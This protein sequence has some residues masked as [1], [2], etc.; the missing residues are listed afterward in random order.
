MSTC[1][2]LKQLHMY[3]CM[4]V[5][6]RNYALT[7]K[8]RAVFELCKAALAKK[9]EDCPQALDVVKQYVAVLDPHQMP[10][11]LCKTQYTD[12]FVDDVNGCIT[13][14]MLAETPEEMVESFDSLTTLSFDA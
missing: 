14:I 6:L 4:M 7:D 12:K 1:P 10:A 5:E 2:S 3:V 11:I 9:V 13:E 8:S